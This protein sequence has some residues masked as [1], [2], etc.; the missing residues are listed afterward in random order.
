MNMVS[1]VGN[2]NNDV[3]DATVVPRPPKPV[4]PP[5]PKPPSDGGNRGAEPTTT[6]VENP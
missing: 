4:P 5:Q 3:K 6:P 2:S 1:M